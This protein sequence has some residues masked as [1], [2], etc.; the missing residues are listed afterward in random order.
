MQRYSARAIL[1]AKPVDVLN[2]FRG[3]FELVFDDGQVIESTGMQL[4]MSRYAWELNK[5]FPNVGLYAR[6]HI[7]TFMKEDT[8]FKPSTILNL[9]SSIMTDIWDVYYRNNNTDAINKMQDELWQTFMDINNAIFNDVMIHGAKNHA[10]MNIEDILEIMLDKEIL[11]IEKKYPV[12]HETVIDP[13][14]VPG[15]YSRKKKVIDQDRFRQNNISILL[16]SGSIKAQQLYQCMG[17]RGSLTDMDSSIFKHPIDT[18][19]FHGLKDIYHVLIESRTAALALN[20]QSGPLKFTEYLSRRVQLIG[21]ELARLHHGDCGSKHH[22]EIQVRGERQGSVMSDLRLLE[23]MNYLDEETGTYRPVRLKDTHLIGKRIKVRT[24]LGCKHKDPNGVCSTC[25]GEASRNIARYRN[26]GHYCV[27]AFTQIITQMVLS[28]KHH[29][30]SATASTVQLFD[31]ALNYLRAI[32]DGLG[33]SIRPDILGKYK[34][35]KLV[36]PEVVFEG[37]SDIREVEDTNILSPRRTSHVNRILL[38]IT[39]KKNNTVDEVLDVVSIRDEGYLSAD[40]LKHM[41]EKGWTVDHDGNIEIDITEYDPEHSVI[42]ITPKQFDMFAYSRG[43]EK[44]LKSSVK[45]IK[46]RNTEVTPESFLMELVDVINTKLEINLSILQIVAY[47]MM[48]TDPS[49]KDYSL[50]KPHTNHAVGTMDHLLIGRSL[51]AALL[52]EK[53]TQIL[54]SVDSF[55]YTNRTDS[56]MDELFVPNQ[57]DLKYRKV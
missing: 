50:P 13:G 42:E 46:R 16:R 14:Y 3:K 35:V 43:I 9:N 48:C 29:I 57:M 4:A 24:V 26:L 7:S 53:Q 30:S 36:L 18:G 28:T 12:N 40:M 19:F 49:K 51:S 56:P 45:D 44:I 15:I 2:N 8:D 20:N 41:K 33:I 10:T 1:N 21:M 38:R 47:T 25:F 17:P 27:I 22:L 23:G 11:D 39:D 5:K 6:H 31:N 37:L 54:S 55:Y 32:Q 52:Y 34:S